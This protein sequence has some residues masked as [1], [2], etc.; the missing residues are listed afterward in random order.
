MISSENFSRDIYVY[1]RLSFIIS[2]FT[3]TPR[4][5]CIMAVAGVLH[6]EGN[7]FRTAMK[8]EYNLLF[9]FQSFQITSFGLGFFNIQV[10]EMFRSASVPL[11][12]IDEKEAETFLHVFRCTLS[13]EGWLLILKCITCKME[14]LQC[15]IASGN[16]GIASGCVLTLL[17]MVFI[18]VSYRFLRF[19]ELRMN[20]L[21]VT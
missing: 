14:F 20:P 15:F 13:I 7:Y 18:V 19:L 5:V 12:N 4:M 2:G 21:T 16:V 6:S 8:Q 9:D 3:Y 11:P 1:R 17:N 10:N